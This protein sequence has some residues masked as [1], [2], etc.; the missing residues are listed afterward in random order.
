MATPKLVYT[1]ALRSLVI[2]HPGVN[3]SIYESLI[4]AYV[5]ELEEMIKDLE[6]EVKRLQKEA[7]A[8]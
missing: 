1:N 7:G 8:E 2:Y 5:I 4:D 6:K 3:G